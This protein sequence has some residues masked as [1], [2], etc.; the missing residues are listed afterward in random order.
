MSISEICPEYFD[1]SVLS[2]TYSLCSFYTGWK[3]IS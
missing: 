2:V 1:L 3:V